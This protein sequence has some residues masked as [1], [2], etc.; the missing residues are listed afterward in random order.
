M[1]GADRSLSLTAKEIAAAFTN[2]IWAERYPPI[3]SL[4]QA[5]NLLQLPKATLYDWRSRGLLNSC[6]RRLGKH[7]RVYRD[8]LIDLVFNRGILND[9]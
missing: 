9:R 2:P 4:E 6:S 1:D 5:A 8:R 7:V 3:L